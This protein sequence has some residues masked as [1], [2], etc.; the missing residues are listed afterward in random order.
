MSEWDKTEI[1]LER[2][3]QDGEL[4]WEDGEPHYQ[5]RHIIRRDSEINQGVYLGGGPREAIVVDP[6]Y[7]SV[8][9]L[10]NE[11]KQLAEQRPGKTKH[12]AIKSA[13]DT[14]QDTLEYDEEE[15]QKIVSNYSAKND[16]KLP[17]DKFIEEGFG[18]CRHQALATG[19]VLEQFQEE[20][21]LTGDISI[22]RNRDEGYGHAWV[23]YENSSGDVYIVD[24][25]QDVL[26]PL[27]RT[28]SERWDYSRP[29]DRI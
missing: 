28:R 26:E 20:G 12:Q 29:E 22:D 16:V 24:P 27:E 13:Y 8:P 14:I 25:T 2:K 10:Y 5:G 21:Y 3:K 11:A 4:E 9:E 19:A 18:L 23:R 6:K 15:V 17:L 7:G 1:L